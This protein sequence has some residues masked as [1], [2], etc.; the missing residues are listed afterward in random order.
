MR[1]FLPLLFTFGSTAVAE[2]PGPAPESAPQPEAEE[3]EAPKPSSP[4][5]LFANGNEL[6]GQLASI[7]REGRLH[8]DREDLESTAV[9]RPGRVSE[10]VFPRKRPE[11]VAEVRFQ[12]LL[13]NGDVLV[14][15]VAELTSEV[16]RLETPFGADFEIPLEQIDE[17]LRLPSPLYAGP[18]HPDEWAP[19][20]NPELAWD[21]RDQ[22]LISQGQSR[23][24]RFIPTPDQVELRFRLHFEGLPSLTIGLFGQDLTQHARNC[25]HL[26][27]NTHYLQ[28]Q[29]H[30]DAEGGRRN[31]GSEQIR[32]LREPGQSVDLRFLVDKS[33][34]RIMAYLDGEHL[35]TWTDELGFAQSGDAFVFFTGA[36]MPVSIQEIQ[37]LPWNGLVSRGELD[38]KEDSDQIFTSDSDRLS[39]EL[40]GIANGQ[41]QMETEFGSLDLAL[42]SAERIT[43][44]QT[45]ADSS[46]ALEDVPVVLAEFWPASSLRFTLEEVTSTH[47][48]GR[49]ELL[50]RFQL[51]RQHLRRLVLP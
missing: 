13:T 9:F 25:Y 20:D 51:S 49:T 11:P 44:S 32:K 43:F 3:T 15:A 42:D 28:L 48:L 6:H 12:C 24:A 38:R 22:S 16:L 26:Q 34:A 39:G 18:S 29:R 40:L 14:G 33:T 46:S 45:E 36:N 5:L 4:H 50:G 47:I 31:L 8:W 23:A 30:S 37:V 7:D 41:I 35:N 10:V 19:E 2:I 21:F 27:L 1:F 17:L